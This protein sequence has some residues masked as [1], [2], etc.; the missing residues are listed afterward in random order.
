MIKIFLSHSS[1]DKD[2]YVEIVAKKLLEK[3]E[4]YALWCYDYRSEVGIDP[5]DKIISKLGESDLFVM[6]ISQYSLNSPFVI[7][8]TDEA[9]KLLKKGSIRRIEAIL[10]DSTI[11]QCTDERIPKH[12]ME[13]P[14]K[15]IKNPLSAACFIEKICTD[16]QIDSK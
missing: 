11:N 7:Q 6:F 8:E 1:K 4:L 16:M 14:I 15:Y 13:N 10:I 12:F 3:P 5:M 2:N 9:I